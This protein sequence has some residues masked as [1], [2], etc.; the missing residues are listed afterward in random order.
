[1]KDVTTENNWTF[2]LGVGDGIDIPIYLI[3]GFMQRDQFNQQHQNNDTFCRSSVVNPLCII[4]SEKIP[5]AG[6]NSNYAFDK[7]SQAFGEIVS[8][9][10]HLAR[11]NILQPYF[12]QKDF[13]TSNNYRDANPGYILFVFD[14]R[15]H[16]DYSS[17]QPVKARFDFRPAFPAATNLIGYALLLS[18]KL[19]SVSSDGQKQIDL[20]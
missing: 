6:I 3:V 19:V 17:A 10:R 2:Q 14:F 20:I 8:C 15:H 16:Q 5:D 4:G 11:D 7:Y 18:N 1:M 9:F 13:I 12:S